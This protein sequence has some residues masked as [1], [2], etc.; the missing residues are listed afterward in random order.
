MSKIFR[1]LRKLRGRS[2]AELQSRAAQALAAYAERSGFSALGSLPDGASLGR[3]LHDSY[4]RGG[5]VSADRLLAH[6]RT[7]RR[8]RFFAALDDPAATTALWRHRFGEDAGGNLQRRADA[9]VEG[10]FDLLGLKGLRF[11]A[12]P[13]AQPGSID[14][15]LDPISGKRAPILHWSLIRYLDPTS[16]GDSKI[17]WELNRHQHFLIL[18]R[19]Y[20]WSGDE[21]YAKAFAAQMLSWMEANPPKLGL[22]W[23]SSLE[24]AFRSISWLWALHFFKHSAALTPTLFISALQFLYV[25]ARHLETY[26]STYFSPNTHLTGEALGLFYLG[27]L[28]PE[29]RRA[30]AWQRIG[31]QTLAEQLG[32]QVRPDGVYF[33]QASYYHRYTTDFYTHLLILARANGLVMGGEVEEK[34]TGLLDHLMFMTRPDGGMPLFGDD[35]G[36]RL[37][38]LDEREPNDFRAALSTGAALFER[39]DYKFVSAYPAEETLWLLGPSGLERLDNLQAR[40]PEQTSRGFPDGG[41][42]VMRGGWGVSDN[43]LVLDCGPHGSLSCGHAHADALSFE[44]AALGRTLL[45]DPG[46]YTYTGSAELRDHFRT[47]AAHNTLTVDGESSSLPGGAFAWKHVAR[48]TARAWV[49]QRRFDYFEGS[50]DGY[51]RL[52]APVEHLR[53]ILFLKGDYWVMRDRVKSAGA[54]IYELNFHF[55]PGANPRVELKD[56]MLTLSE[57]REGESGLGIAVFCE[58]GGTWREREGRVSQCYGALTAAPTCVFSASAVGDEDFCTFLMPRAANSTVARV[59]AI[60]AAG[61]RAIE[62]R[63]EVAHDLLMTCAGGGIETARFTSDFAWT[64]ARFE[65]EGGALRE[66]LLID[67]SRLRLDGREL[68]CAQG[69]AGYAVLTFEGEELRVETDARGEYAVGVEGAQT[70]AVNGRDFAAGEVRVLRFLDGR[71]LDAAAGQAVPEAPPPK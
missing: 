61:G 10:R 54:H 47:S 59:R 46:T 55:A 64:W 36:G 45:V 62:V 14:W 26:L 34:L 11:D 27:T 19:A 70:V 58:G 7:R 60:K 53:S 39:P 43:Y 9:I 38:P 40:V 41:Y 52:P 2:F 24:V 17:T 51:R 68:F 49:S 12:G 15:H 6:F 67:G 32:R 35:D 28:L 16:V 21:R 66:L 29:F 18:G 5:E 65:R 48:S 13:G 25:H 37:T 71:P 31:L 23:S 69:R 22:N 56:D 4:V 42:Y 63:T 50:H 1:T 20:F 57:G 8:P 44:L 33:E 3:L 30:Q